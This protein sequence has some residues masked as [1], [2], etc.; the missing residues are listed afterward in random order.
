[1]TSPS[2]QKMVEAARSYLGHTVL[3]GRLDCSELVA[4]C[5]IAC[6]LPDRRSTWRAQTFADNLQPID[7]PEPGDLGF[8]GLDWQHVVHVVIYCGP[9][10]IISASGATSRVRTLKEAKARGA[11]V[12]SYTTHLYRTDIPFLG[13]RRSPLDSN[14][15]NPH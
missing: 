5:F 6:G 3:W 8:F 1:M 12:R 11:K 4:N 13:W 7:K 15:H 14:G 9:G 10:E 2:R